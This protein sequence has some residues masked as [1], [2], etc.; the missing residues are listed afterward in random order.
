MNTRWVSTCTSEDC[1]LWKEVSG[2]SIHYGTLIQGHEECVTNYHCKHKR[3]LFTKDKM[4]AMNARF[5]FQTVKS[6]DVIAILSFRHSI[7]I[8][9]FTLVIHHRAR[10]VL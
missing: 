3:S 5:R 7:N 4:L 9:Y 8:L 6:H 10:L 2:S 1:Q